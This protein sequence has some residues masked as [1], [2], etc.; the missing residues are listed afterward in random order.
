MFERGEACCLVVIGLFGASAL[1]A[2]EKHN[3]SSGIVVTVERN[4]ICIVYL[5]R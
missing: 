5:L 1:L 3:I 2:K 4:Q